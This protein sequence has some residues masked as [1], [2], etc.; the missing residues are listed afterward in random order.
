[1]RKYTASILILAFVATSAVAVGQED[2]DQFKVPPQKPG[3]RPAE[4]IALGAK[5]TL[6]PASNYEHCT[7]PGDLEQLTDGLYSEGYF[8]VQKSTVGWKNKSHIVVTLDLGNVKPV[9]GASF[10]TAAGRAGVV[11]PLA[12]YIFVA[13]EDKQ[14]HEAGE[15]VALSAQNGLPGVEEYGTH[16]YWTDE[17]R[18][19][20]R[21][22]SFVIAAKPYAFVDELEVYA[23][24]P[25]WLDIP[26]EGKSITDI[27]GHMADLQLRESIMRRLRNDIDAVRQAAGARGVSQHARANVLG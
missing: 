25:A 23:G 27:K 6:E 18:T 2:F 14:F 13:G 24:E 5:Y 26:L 15:L 16:R 3:T 19:H 1:M 8:W 10:H 4:N 7:D 12:I 22:I 21:Y 9:R 20:G 11:W 17:L